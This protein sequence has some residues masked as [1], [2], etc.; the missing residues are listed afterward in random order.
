MNEEKIK[1][2]HS[3]LLIQQKIATNVNKPQNF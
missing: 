1:Q 3:K 2:V